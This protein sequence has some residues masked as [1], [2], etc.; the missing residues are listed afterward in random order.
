MKDNELLYPPVE[1]ELVE[2]SECSV[3]RLLGAWGAGREG[4]R[5]VAVTW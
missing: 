2:K 4:V 1:D 3:P 5:E